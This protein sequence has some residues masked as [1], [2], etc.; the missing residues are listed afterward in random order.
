M[1]V[2]IVHQPRAFSSMPRSVSPRNRVCTAA[3]AAAS[4]GFWRL[5]VDC[6]VSPGSNPSPVDEGHGIEGAIGALGLGPWLLWRPV[7]ATRHALPRSLECRFGQILR[8]LPPSPSI[9]LP[10]QIR[11]DILDRQAARTS[12]DVGMHDLRRINPR[13]P[14]P[15]TV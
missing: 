7:R 2:P 10:E 1:Y 5:K 8:H 6:S 15:R 3:A 12:M 13:L 9:H 14:S 11:D 4:S